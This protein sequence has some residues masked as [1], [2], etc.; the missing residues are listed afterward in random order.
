MN[1]EGQ[2][3]LLNA[4]INSMNDVLYLQDKDHNIVLMNQAG[5]KYFNLLNN[6]PTGAKCFNLFGLEK[7]CLNCPCIE[8]RKTKKEVRKSFF[9]TEAQLWLDIN[10]TPS[11][12]A[13][14]EINNVLVRFRDVSHEKRYQNITNSYGDDMRLLVNRMPLGCIVWDKDFKVVHWNTAAEKIFGFTEKEAVGKHPYEMIVPKEMVPTTDEIKANLLKG[15]ETAHRHG[16]NITKDG[17]VIFCDWTNTPLRDADGQTR[18]VLSVVQDVTERML[19]EQALRDSE[20]KFRDLFHKHSAVKLLFEPHS[21]QIVDA[22]EAAAQFYGWSIEQL[23]QMRIDEINVLSPEE[24]LS[25]MEKAANQKRI[26]FEFIHRLADGTQKDVAVFR[27]KIT[28]DGKELL[29]SIIQDISEYKKLEAQLLQSQKMES[30]G[31]LAGGVAHDINNMLSVMMGHATVA[32]SKL[33]D[34]DPLYA[35]FSEINSAGQ[36]SAEITKKL[37]AF[38][39]KQ[40]VVPKV[41]NLND[42]LHGMLSMLQRLLGEDIDLLWK[43][44]ANLKPIKID[45]SQ[46]DQILMNLCVNARDAINGV[47][48]LTIETGKA[49]FDENY[50]AK[51]AGFSPGDFNLLAVSDNGSGMDTKTLANIFEPFFSTKDVGKGTGL[52]L[53]TVYGIVKQNNGFIN[54]YSE[55]GHGT[56]FR[57]YFPQHKSEVKKNSKISID[58]PSQGEGQK[59]LVVEDDAALRI[60]SEKM[61]S[62][63]NYHVISV[64]SPLEALQVVEEHNGDIDLLLTDIVMPEM[65]GKQLADA[66][67]EKHPGIKVIYMS[68]YT[69]NVISHH[70]VLEEGVNFLQKPITLSE[71]TDKVDEVLNRQ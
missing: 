45:P 4:V 8:A 32:L 61:L 60:V 70:G 71:L 27:S 18:G 58:Q 38:A 3:E 56:T 24:M 12:D 21:G 43:P 33:D 10:V 7:P 69:S 36:R 41:L 62:Q 46:L 55:P 64:S 39:R 34:T 50:C 57:L 49:S 54:V 2:I 31:R 13:N 14:G 5:Y 40:A 37:L 68:G 42:A 63:N 26:H 9:H 22:N 11:L 52:G 65:N 59:I 29:H 47:G 17:R 28:I 51:H 30:I 35:T 66:I 23:K 44:K 1:T 16:K 67:H 53:A 20:A 19:T 15:D 6:N 48:K 25:E